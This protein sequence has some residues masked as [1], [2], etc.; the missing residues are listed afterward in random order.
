MSLQASLAA[1]QNAV[2]CDRA[3]ALNALVTQAIECSRQTQ[4]LQTGDEGPNFILSDARGSATALR[5]L[6]LEGP[7][8]IVFCRGSWCPYCSAELAAYQLALP[9]ITARGANLVAISPEI[10]DDSL[11]DNEIDALDFE[12]LSDP[13]NLTARKFGLV[14]ALDSESRAQFE[15]FGL[16]LEAANGDA[17]WRLPIPATFLIDN[18][19]SIVFAS[20][21]PDYRQ[22][23]EPA[24]VVAALDN[25]SGRDG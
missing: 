20:A 5:A 2:P 22:R 8:V 1:I 24:D 19:R 9:A 17:S 23:A 4:P 11:T 6:L 10:R 16:N 7:A 3:G 25:L 21:E 15:A 12:V 18:D 14:Y 13:G